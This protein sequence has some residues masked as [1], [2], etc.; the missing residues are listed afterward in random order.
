MRFIIKICACLFFIFGCCYAQRRQHVFKNI[1]DEIIADEIDLNQKY[2]EEDFNEPEVN[3]IQYDT[4]T[5]NRKRIDGRSNYD[6]QT[7]SRFNNQQDSYQNRPYQERDQPITQNVNKF[8]EEWPANPITNDQLY[9][10]QQQFRTQPHKYGQQHQSYS[11]PATQQTSPYQQPLCSHFQQFNQ[12]PQRTKQCRQPQQY[13]QNIHYQRQLQLG[14][15]LGNDFIP[16]NS[17]YAP[18]QYVDDCIENVPIPPLMG[19]KPEIAQASV[20]PDQYQNVLRDNP[21]QAL[22][23][24]QSYKKRRR[25]S[26]TRAPFLLLVGAVVLA[27]FFGFIM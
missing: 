12:Q 1:V 16:D 17:A 6:I 24:K 27:I 22:R 13:G 26:P 15:K 10:E 4:R 18:D 5:I 7:N 2:P 9:N 21:N 14:Q 8:E 23:K 19:Q 25:F 11:Q 3:N 20:N